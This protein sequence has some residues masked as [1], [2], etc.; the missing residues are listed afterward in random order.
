MIA[1]EPGSF[2][3]IAADKVGAVYY[4]D[5]FETDTG[6][7]VRFVILRGT[8]SLCA[9]LGIPVP[10]PLANRD[11]DS[12]SLNCHG[13]LTYGADHLYGVSEPADGWYWY[14]WDYAHLGDKNF[15]DLQT[16]PPRFADSHGWT[17]AEVVADSVDTINNLIVLLRESENGPSDQT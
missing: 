12:L 11:Y 5:Q 1:P 2:E 4:D 14:G 13:G 3:E 6:H 8:A 17:P 10:H 15:W 9:Y 7:P 16:V